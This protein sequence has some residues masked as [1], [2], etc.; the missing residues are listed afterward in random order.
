[1]SSRIFETSRLTV[2]EIKLD[3]AIEKDYH[4]M[5]NLHIDHALKLSLVIFQSFN[6]DIAANINT[7]LKL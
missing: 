5:M 4:S 1:M 6:F 7:K 2:A 3:I